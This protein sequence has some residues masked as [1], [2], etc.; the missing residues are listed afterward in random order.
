MGA[1]QI[2]A[3]RPQ[4]QRQAAQPGES[5]VAAAVAAGLTPPPGAVAAGAVAAKQAA[6]KQ[7]AG[8]QAAGQAAGMLGTSEAPVHRRPGRPRSEHADQA[9]I[10]AALSVLAD[11]GI[12]G[13]CIEAVA[14]RAGV[15]KATIYRRWPGKEDLL[16]DAVSA[17]RTP[18]PEPKGKSVRADLVAL[19]EAMCREAADP[20][21]RRLSGLR[22]GDGA[23]YPRLAARYAENV[24]EPRREVVRS[25]L[26]R[27]VATGEL[28]E[29]ADIDAALFL[30]TGAVLARGQ[31]GQER[32]EAGYA[33]R[34]VEELLRGLSSR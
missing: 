21:R 22:Q 23:R 6:G 27:G 18:L 33:R 25:V 24:A 29:G 5:A 2:L 14:A 30:L 7:G 16:L 20:R 8:K 17:L 19:L 12:D 4:A 9:I 1:R 10:E 15:G 32:P 3:R 13:L 31:H 28:R 11:E 26:R 34:I